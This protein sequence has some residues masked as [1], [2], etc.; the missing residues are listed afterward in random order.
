MVNEKK[1]VLL[2]GTYTN[3][4]G[5]AIVY[6]T[7]KV[8]EDLGIKTK[9]IVDPD[10]LFPDTFY[11]KFNLIPVYRWSHT[12]GRG[13]T[14]SLTLL[15]SIIP[16]VYLVKNSFSKS[17]RQLKGYPIWYIGD[18]SLNDYGSVLA[19]FGQI[20]NL[21]SLKTLTKGKMIINASMGYMRTETG[22]TLLKSLLGHIDYFLVRGTSSYN[23]ITQRGVPI[24]KVSMVCDMAYFLEKVQTH[25]TTEIFNLISKSKKPSIA[26]IFKEYSK[27]K[28]RS[29]YI[30]SVKQLESTLEKN[31]NIFYV[32]TSYVPYKNEND[33]EF[34]NGIGAKN[35]LD[36]SHLDP[37]EII[38]VFTNFT[39]VVTLRL[40]GA[41]YS[42][43]AGV[44]TY[45]IYEADNSLD[46]IKDTFGEIVPLLHIS[47]FIGADVGNISKEIED[48][49]L[50]RDEISQSMNKC[51]E[52]NKMRTIEIIRT[53]V[54]NKI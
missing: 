22:E 29:N 25:Q 33:L 30:D 51:I 18:S 23:N 10:P 20:I 40:H 11:E 4:G 37:N 41:V 46:V 3:K 12:F 52:E 47:N 14:K 6:G 7:L 15:S 13:E 32:P 48:L 5:L 24:N 39:A 21:M 35:I 54:E 45:H 42:T 17:I 16:F 53:T 1:L 8:L 38:E 50:R 43:L 31:Y 49:I 2:S 34:L 27:E 19:L 28:Q 44:P 9:Y 26:L 36:I